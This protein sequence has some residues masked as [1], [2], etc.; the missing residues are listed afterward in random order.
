MAKVYGY[1][2]HSTNHQAITEEVQRQQVDAY[3][4]YQLLPKGE[5]L[6]DPFWF[7][8]AATS[9]GKPL[10]EREQ[11]LRMWCVL[12]PGDHIVVAKLD[13]AFRSVIDGVNCIEML[14]AKGVHL[15]ILD[16][17]I[18]TSS[19]MGQFHVTIMLAFAQLQRQYISDRTKE[20]MARKKES[21][22]WVGNGANSV[23]FGWKK[24]GKQGYLFKDEEERS[25]IEQIHQWREEGL[26]LYSIYCKANSKQYRWARKG[27]SW[28]PMT[29]K[30]ALIAR[31]RGYPKVIPKSLLR[32]PVV[33]GVP[34]PADAVACEGLDPAPV[35]SP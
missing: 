16:V 5:E 8:D 17:H 20:V 29:V 34:L 1:G 18:D 6:G 11:G 10:T 7:Y 32:T 4:K 25:R 9:G 12:Q 2:R 24:A 35:Q 28:E 19:A 14:K 23:P 31:D 3:C 21:G 13:R 27:R 30:A 26:S 22:K 33:H 15:H